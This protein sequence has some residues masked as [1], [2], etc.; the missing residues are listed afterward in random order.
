MD[1]KIPLFIVTGASGTGKTTVSK[2]LRK[3][4]PDVDVFEL[5]FIH[6]IVG[7][8]DW[9]KIENIW[10]RVARNVA[11]SGRISIICGTMMP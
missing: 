5:D 4:L 7:D 10:F 3:L 9:R 1:E 11:A 2:E 8:D 6:R